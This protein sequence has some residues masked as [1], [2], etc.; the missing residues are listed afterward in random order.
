M[1]R[2]FRRTAT[3]R[4]VARRARSAARSS[5]WLA[6][7]LLAACASDPPAP[8]LETTSVVDGAAQGDFE[9][10]WE[11]YLRQSPP[12]AFAFAYDGDDWAWGRYER[13]A[14]VDAARRA[15]L[16]LCERAR[17]ERGIRA[18]C[19]IYAQDSEIVWSMRDHLREFQTYPL[20]RAFWVA[21]PR[22][23]P[24]FDAVLRATSPAAAS[25]Q[26]LNDCRTALEGTGIEHTCRICQIDSGVACTELEAG[27]TPD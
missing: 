20:H 1:G 2:T 8:D 27:W 24:I 12:K 15:A 19:A 6:A 17:S 13:A 23:R 26:A 5:A 22:S 3:A 16:D 25:R 4:S 9:S 7:I 14:S 18:P 10:L 21:G 11:E